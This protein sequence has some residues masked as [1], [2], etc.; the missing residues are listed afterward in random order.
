M[1]KRIAGIDAF[2]IVAGPEQALA[3][4]LAL[5]A[6]DGAE[7]SSRFAIVDR[8]R[9]SPRTSVATGRKRRRLRLIGAVRAAKTLNGGIRAPAGLQQ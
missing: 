9:F 4:G 5:A 3:S 8:N 1:A 2:E 7:E 6:G